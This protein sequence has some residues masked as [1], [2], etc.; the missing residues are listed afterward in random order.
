MSD[1]KII[2]YRLVGGCLIQDLEKAVNNLIREGWQPF[3]TIDG[4][5]IWAQPM[6]KYDNSDREA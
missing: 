6:V 4:N 1:R 3:G 2:A 5:G